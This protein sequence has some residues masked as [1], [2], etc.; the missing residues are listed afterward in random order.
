M[1]MSVGAWLDA[2]ESVEL[3]APEGGLDYE[4]AFAIRALPQV[5]VRVK[6]R[7]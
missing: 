6:R 1:I 7:A 2:F 5:P 4:P 3:V